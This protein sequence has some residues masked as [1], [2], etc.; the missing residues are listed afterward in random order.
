[1]LA[2]WN[3]PQHGDRHDRLL[4][5]RH[6][7]GDTRL[8]EVSAVDE[9]QPA[10]VDA[11]EQDEQHAGEEGRQ[12]KADK[13]EGAG[14]AVEPRVGL[15]GGQHAHRQRHHQRQ[16]L[17]QADDGDRHRQALQDQRVHVD[18]AD[19]GEAPVAAHH[20][21]QPVEVALPDR[22]VQPEL[23]AQ[24]HAHLRRHVGVLRQFLEGVARRQRQ[25]REQDQA[26]A[27]QAGQ[28]D[29]QPPENVVEQALPGREGFRHRGTRRP[30]SWCRCPRPTAARSA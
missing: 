17:R 3:R 22:V 13:G 30:G 27:Q 14:D 15:D 11:E 23:C 1:M 9:G 10:Q 28:G 24:R 25:H 20:V 21:Q 16:H 6:P 2:A 29:Q 8:A 19:E 26:D 4:E 18:A 5:L 7:P 12:R